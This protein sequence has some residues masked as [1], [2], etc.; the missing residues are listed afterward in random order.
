MYT[1]STKIQANGIR[2]VKKIVYLVLKYHGLS[3]IVLGTGLTLQGV[4]I[5]FFL[6]PMK[7]PIK[8]RGEEQQIHRIN[9]ETTSKNFN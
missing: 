1:S 3:G 9:K 2:P 4:F 7:E 5:G 8:T 6:I